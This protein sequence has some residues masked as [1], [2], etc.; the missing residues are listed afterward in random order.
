MYGGEPVSVA[1]N[2]PRDFCLSSEPELFRILIRNI[3]VNA[4]VHAPGEVV[5]LSLLKQNTI[6]EFRNSTVDKPSAVSKVYKPTGLGLAIVSRIADRLNIR[7]E[8]GTDAGDFFIRLNL[9]QMVPN[10]SILL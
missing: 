5:K 2:C 3:I 1:W 7:L 4:A 6:L 9:D 8:Y 10:L